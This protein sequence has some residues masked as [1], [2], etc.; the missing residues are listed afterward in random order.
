[1]ASIA[2]VVIMTDGSQMTRTA[3][4]ADADVARIIGWAMNYYPT[5]L[6]AQGQ[7]LPKTHQWAINRW[8]EAIVASSFAK[9]AAYEQTQA[10]AAAVVNV[11]PPISFSIT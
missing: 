6:D 2:F 8:I 11:P 1:M 7:P 9:V 3:A 4:V 10:T 5:E